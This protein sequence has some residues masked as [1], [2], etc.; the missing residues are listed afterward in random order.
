MSGP[1][2]RPKTT[3]QGVDES[4]SVVTNDGDRFVFE[5][6]LLFDKVACRYYVPEQWLVE[7]LERA[8]KITEDAERVMGYG[9]HVP[10][11]IRALKD[12]L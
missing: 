1:F 10:D 11:K 4:C 5:G 7:K 2:R 12:S 9:S 8:A 3:V 6:N